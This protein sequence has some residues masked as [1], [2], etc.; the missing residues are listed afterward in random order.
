M[1][2]FQKQRLVKYLVRIE[3]FRLSLRIISQR[4]MFNQS[5]KI[6]IMD[7]QTVGI[8]LDVV[9]ITV[10]LVSIIRILVKHYKQAKN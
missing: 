7:I 3:T 5:L 8:T 6:T 10:L 2:H 4:S 1:D 9:L